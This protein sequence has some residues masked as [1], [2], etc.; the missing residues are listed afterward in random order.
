M[1]FQF[2]TAAR[3]ASLDAIETAIGA[4]PILRIRSGAAPANCAA[5]RTGTI[6]A[7]MTLPADFMAAAS[8]GSKGLSGTWQDAA[9]DAAGTAGHFEIMDA[10]GTTCHIQGSVTGTGGGGDMEIQ[11]TSIAAGQQI[12]VTAFNI[13]AGGA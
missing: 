1:T 12:T 11:N 10:S 9:A 6:L 8:G 7:T 2:S 3:N 4:S 13:T 5:A